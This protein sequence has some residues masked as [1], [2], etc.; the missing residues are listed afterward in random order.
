LAPCNDARGP[1]LVDRGFVDCGV[2]ALRA[3]RRARSS[4][5][6]ALVRSA[7]SAWCS[8]TSCTTK[9]RA[10]PRRRRSGSGTS[11]PAPSACSAAARPIPR[12]APVTKATWPSRRFMPASLLLGQFPREVLV[13]RS[14]E[15]TDTAFLIMAKLDP[16]VFGGLH[17]L[18]HIGEGFHIL[19]KHTGQRR[20]YNV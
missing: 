7:W 16:L 2:L 20:A 14:V 8:F 17:P 19:I 3:R 15:L 10:A 18:L 5:T 1:P 9:C 11:S 6:A 12:K 13:H 4:G